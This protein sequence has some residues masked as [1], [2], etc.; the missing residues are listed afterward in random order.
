MKPSTNPHI[1]KRLKE[2]AA[3]IR[4]QHS[5][6][7]MG[8]DVNDLARDM[9]VG[10][11]DAIERLRKVQR[12]VG[13][14]I[15]IVTGTEV[16]VVYSS[17][18][19]SYTDGK[20]VVLSA[21]PDPT[22][23]DAMCGTALH[24]ASHI[25]KSSEALKF[26]PDMHQ[27]FATMVKDTEL[28]ALAKKLGL[29]L[30]PATSTTLKPDPNAP[31][32]TQQQGETVV[33]H[34]Q[35]VMNVLEDRRIDLW[36]Y[37]QAPG[38]QPY[39][40]A[41]YNEYW[42]SSKIDA[43]LKSSDFREKTVENYGM[44]VI[45]MTNPNWD[46]NALPALKE[47][48][49]IANLS[50]A[51]LEARGDE[52]PGFK[53]WRGELR[54]APINLNKFPKLFADAVRIV[55]LMYKNSDAV[56][57]SNKKDPQEPE[58]GE[59]GENGGDLPN[60]DNGG[61]PSRKQ[62]R[63]A[64]ARQKKFLSHDTSKAQ[65]DDTSK[66]Q[67]DQME[68]TKATVTD[69]EGDFLPKNVKA[70]VIIYRDC[71]KKAVQADAFPFKYGRNYYGGRSAGGRNHE[72]E[73]ALT[74]GIRLGQVLSHRLRIM[75][76]EKPLTFNHQ[77]HGRLDK[78]RVAALGHGGEDVF[79]FT[80]IEKMKPANLWIDIDF[81]GSMQGT[82]VRQ[83]MTLAIAVAFA[84]AKTRTLNVTIAVRDGGNDVAN[85]AILYDS[86]KHQFSRLREI[87]PFIDA[88]G[89]TPESLCFEAVKSEILKSYGNERK[90]FIN[91]S[92]GAPGHG[93]TYKGAHY[94]YGSESAYKHCRQL[95]N[96][97]RQ[98]GIEVMSYFIG[99]SHSGMSGMNEN[100]AFKKMYGTDA[101]FINPESV[102]AIAN[103]I[104]KMLLK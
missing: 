63:E 82:K 97:F 45:N 22:I 38:Y 86:R 11:I 10:S 23:L 92:D 37:Q 15:K 40:D 18:Q 13:N 93:F 85:V 29:S 8:N 100:P 14:L 76:D 87:V 91:L 98:S 83:A 43:A 56:Q 50:E 54:Q 78:R 80:I 71:T 6:F 67:L 66:A 12:G 99:D 47:I 57:N 28:P 53:T 3:L 5:T 30:V 34:V 81:S 59:G 42:H 89:G 72:M 74:Q 55:E 46:S 49:K 32:M 4:K 48:R 51:G 36:Q 2:K 33:Q 39:Y 61:P 68:Q 58:E 60:M 94:S 21:S 90:Y 75:S 104:N 62:V 64:I 19:Q 96:E 44:F 102:T 25:V 9:E 70:R 52:D 41:M 101:R 95:M 17:G 35:M 27:Q 65:L 77:K 73:T 88:A 1:A 24:E 16:P 79:S 26:L 7:W 84:A 103:T 20:S 31:K 69:V